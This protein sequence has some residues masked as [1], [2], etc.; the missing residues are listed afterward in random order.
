VEGED[1]GRLKQ[2]KVRTVGCGGTVGMANS[3][4]WEGRTVR[5]VWTVGK[6]DSG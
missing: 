3:G 5:C 4:Q 2:S 1:S 6:V